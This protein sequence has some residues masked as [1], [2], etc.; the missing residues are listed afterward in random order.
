[1]GIA[2]YQQNEADHLREASG[3][4]IGLSLLF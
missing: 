4:A 2:S 1:M 3:E